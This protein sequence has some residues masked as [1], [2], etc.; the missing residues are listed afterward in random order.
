MD[1]S[2]IA[3]LL[4]SA[5]GRTLTTWLAVL[6]ALVLVGVYVYVELIA[7]DEKP[8]HAATASPAASPP[9]AGP[10]APASVSRPADPSEVEGEP[11]DLRDEGQDPFDDTAPA[12][13][14]PPSTTATPGGTDRGERST[15][16]GL[17]ETAEG[18]GR[19]FTNTQGGQRAW[20]ERLAA[21]L[22]ADTAAPYKNVPIENVPTGAVV[23]VELHELAATVGE[24]RLTY[25]TGLVIDIRLAHNAVKWEVVSVV[26]RVLPGRSPVAN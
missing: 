15:P 23:N 8:E 24:A 18:F 22:N 26:D 3:A 20:Y 21:F 4:G 1:N 25:D 13:S 7:G 16:P 9:S 5:R 19:A 10:T 11:G 2:R 14:S 6:V 17:R 12:V